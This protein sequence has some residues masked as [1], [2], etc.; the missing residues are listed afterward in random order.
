M[1]CLCRESQPD[2]S[3]VHHVNDHHSD[4]AIMVHS[5]LLEQRRTNNKGSKQTESEISVIND[6]LNANPV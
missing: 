1:F 3:V 5:V 6:S 4:C 2:F